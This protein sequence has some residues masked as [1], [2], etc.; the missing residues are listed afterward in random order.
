MYANPIS[1][2]YKITNNRNNKFYI[3]SSVDIHARWATHKYLLSGNKHTS[4]HLQNAWNLYGESDFT[5]S[6][7]EEIETD[8]L[9]EREQYWLDLNKT[10]ESEN[11]YNILRKAGT[12]LGFEHSEETKL[13]IGLSAKGKPK[14][15]KKPKKQKEIKIR[16]AKLIGRKY[17][18]EHKRKISESNK[19]RT[20]SEEHKIKLRKP[21]K[22]VLSGN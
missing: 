20:L 8:K 11:G 5:F 7:I 14:P 19:N 16:G 13:K 2:I 4:K 1:G 17:S 21:K 18:E 10:Y 6:I 3:G 22:K 9:I 15:R 12:T